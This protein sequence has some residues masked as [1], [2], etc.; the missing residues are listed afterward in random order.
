MVLLRNCWQPFL[1]RIPFIR[2]LHCRDS[3]QLLIRMRFYETNLAPLS[4]RSSNCYGRTTSDR[5]DLLQRAPRFT[6]MQQ[7]SSPLF[8]LSSLRY[9]SIFIDIISLH[10][11]TVR[12][13]SN[14]PLLCTKIIFITVIEHFIWLFFLHSVLSRAMMFCLKYIRYNEQRLV[15]KTHP[16]NNW[17]GFMWSPYCIK[18]L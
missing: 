2:S 7:L 3:K 5:K 8:S 9:T 10:I 15:W 11:L 4:R 1:S 18:L 12:S 6:P 14:F 17:S 16:R 13:E